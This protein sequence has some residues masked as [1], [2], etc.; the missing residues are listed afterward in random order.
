MSGT[1]GFGNG[2]LRLPAATAVEPASYA[3]GEVTA[4]DR[5]AR[6][7]TV[8]SIAYRVDSLFDM[9]DVTASVTRAYL[10][11]NGVPNMF[12]VNMGGHGNTF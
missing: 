3:H 12:G 8:G 6:T 1:A 9:N 5:R 10:T 11:E 4:V 7:L 2:A